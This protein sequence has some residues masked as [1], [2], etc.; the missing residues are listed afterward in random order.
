MQKNFLLIRIIEPNTN[1]P[2]RK[3]EGHFTKEVLPQN[4]YIMSSKT[5]EDLEVSPHLHN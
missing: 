2:K 4:E 1:Q 3:S 5:L